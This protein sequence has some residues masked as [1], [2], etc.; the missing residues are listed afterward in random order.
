MSTSSLFAVAVVV[1]VLMV[2]GLFFTM[3]EFLELSDDPSQAKDRQ[4]QGGDDA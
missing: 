2:T 4:L 1:F 3:N